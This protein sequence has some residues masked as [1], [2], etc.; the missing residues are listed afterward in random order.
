MTKRI[1]LIAFAM[2]IIVSNGIA[3]VT[4][5]EQG[6]VVKKN[7]DLLKGLKKAEP[8]DIDAGKPLML[9]PSATPIYSDNLSLIEGDEFMRI[10]M[11]G[12]YIPEPYIDNNK[13][14]KAFVLRKATEQEKA[15]M[16]E[17]QGDMQSE[18]QNKNDLIGKEAFSFSVTDILGNTYSLEKLKGKVIVINFV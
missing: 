4:N 7:I 11:S 10:M 15:Q 1:W 12:D 17:M 6:T 18:K 3:Q 13:E 14:V 8:G 9:D 16:K 2:V 5:L